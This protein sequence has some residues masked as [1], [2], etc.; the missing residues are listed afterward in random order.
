VT[1]NS[2]VLDT[3]ARLLASHASGEALEKADASGWNAA[4]WEVMVDLGF[5]WI[6]LPAGAG[7][8]GG[9]VADLISVIIETGKSAPCAPVADTGLLAGWLLARAG[10]SL[11]TSVVTVIPPRSAAGLTVT[12][13]AGELVLHG[14]APCVPWASVSDTLLAVIRRPLH[15]A[16]ASG[17]V[18]V[19]VGARDV[20]VRPRR[21]LAGELRD[22]ATF[23]HVRVAERDVAPLPAGVDA[24]AL[25]CRGALGRAALLV[26][27][28]VRV[29]EITTAYAQERTQFG[30][31]IARF[32]AV[33]H[34]LALIAE[35]TAKATVAVEAAALLFDRSPLEAAAFAKIVAGDAAT[36]VAARAHQVHAAIGMTREYELHRHT[37]ALYAWSAEYG[38]EDEWSARI[39]Q[40]LL[41]TGSNELWPRLSQSS[42]LHQRPPTIEA[43]AHD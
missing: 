39:G 37:R 20:E 2:L 4:A 22:V 28:M 40:D 18:L 32:Q 8:G 31:P 43:P 14:I 34:S 21:N 27:A 19:R 38:T 35:H 11:P 9:T 15:E 1:A 29:Q 10:W 36:L 25:S 3:I 30:S 12:S 41:S 6:A 26:G 7:G 16:R 23:D 17:H 24:D 5:P 33:S 42:S 13:N